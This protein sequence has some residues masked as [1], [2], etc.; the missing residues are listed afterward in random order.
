MA[1]QPIPKTVSVGNIRTLPDFSI[2]IAFCMFSLFAGKIIVVL[3][4]IP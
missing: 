4:F 2:S 1:R 3:S